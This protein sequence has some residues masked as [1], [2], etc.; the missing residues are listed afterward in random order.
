VWRLKGGLDGERV[1]VRRICRKDEGRQKRPAGS[2]AA[3]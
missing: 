1:E 3:A 2:V